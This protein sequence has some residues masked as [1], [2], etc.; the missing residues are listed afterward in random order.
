RA[1]C[2]TCLPE[3]EKERFEKAF[4]G[5][6]LAAL[7]RKRAAGLDPTHGGL[8]AE[9]R[10]ASLAERRRERLEWEQLSG[11]APDPALFRGEILPAIAEVPLSRLVA[12][13]G[14][15][16]RYCSQIRRGERTPHP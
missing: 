12:A 10:A 7:E 2:D 4:S 14:L 16:L 6:G 15:S 1:Y 9:R 11:P 3:F 8:A 5:S 13:T